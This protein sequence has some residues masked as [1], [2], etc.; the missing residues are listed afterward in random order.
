MATDMQQGLIR[1]MTVLLFLLFGGTILISPLSAAG[2]QEEIHPETAA[3]NI[4]FA[5]P[6]QFKQD[7]Y[8]VYIEKSTDA[9]D[10]AGPVPA[11][12]RAGVRHRLDVS[13]IQVVNCAIA[14][15]AVATIAAARLR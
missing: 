14:A 8:I 4:N 13:M 11:H 7:S 9:R 2:Q 6:S 12:A 15:R 10:A 1:A 5:S 3:L